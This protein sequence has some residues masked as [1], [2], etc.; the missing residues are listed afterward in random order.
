MSLG[1]SLIALS[2]G[3]A[4][5]YG[6]W[7][8]GG[9]PSGWRT[10]I[11]TAAVGGLAAVALVAGCPGAL[12]AALV[13]GAAG[14]AL[15]EGETAWRRSL[16]AAALLFARLTYARLFLH[17]GGG[18]IALLAEP[19]RNLGVA[20]A[21]AVGLVVALWLWDDL[22]ALKPPAAAFAAAYALT[23]TIMA[24]LAFTLP[25]WLWPAMAGAVVLVLADTLLAGRLI[26]GWRTPALAWWTTYAA[27]A[28][29]LGAF[30]R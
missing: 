18:R 20:G 29:I 27:Q 28:L 1:Y 25:R 24:G 21:M 10:L 2:A 23:L 7:L 26:K 17:D 3:S 30:L 15:L 11:R 22:V 13:L 8:D 12:V 6:A 19:W 16:G 5:V 14:D 4:G 9:R